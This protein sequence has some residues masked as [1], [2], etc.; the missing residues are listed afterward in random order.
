MFFWGLFQGGYWVQQGP[1][2]SQVIDESIVMTGGKRNEGIYNG[3]QNFIGRL[4]LVVQ[5]V[6]FAVVHT[7]TGFVEGAPLAVQ[8]PQAITGIHIHFALIPMILM[9]IA[10]LWFGKFYTLTP[11]KVKANSQKIIQMES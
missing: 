7:L 3:V 2:L 8:P 5:A 10:T 4:A 6:S 9:L 1:I 11:D